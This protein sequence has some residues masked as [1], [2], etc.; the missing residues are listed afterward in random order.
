MRR[1][2]TSRQRGTVYLLVLVVTAMLVGI[3]VT[4]VMAGRI[5]LQGEVLEDDQA[6][7]RH[8][9]KGMLEAIRKKLESSPGWRTK[10][11]HDT[12]SARTNV[13]GG[14]YTYKLV[15]E[16]DGSLSDDDRDPVRVYVKAIVG[17]A[18]RVYSMVL[19]VGVPQRIEVPVVRS[20]DD[21]GQ[22]DLLGLVGTMS[23]A[24]L[25]G[26]DGLSGA[27]AAVRFDDLPVGQGAAVLSAQIQFTSKDS[28][29]DATVMAIAAEDI[30]DAP[31][32]AAVPYSIFSRT[33]TTA[34]VAWIPGRWAANDRGDAQL[35]PDLAEMVQEVVDRPGWEPGNAMVFFVDSTQARYLRTYDYDPD[36]AAVLLVTY[37]DRGLTPDY[38]SL[39]RELVE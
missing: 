6:Q 10:Y 18:V 28:Q 23:N 12:W 13:G 11:A 3:G 14:A 29:S 2:S 4:A 39:R 1:R 37:I 8:L 7:A 26:Q 35:T 30:D 32:F 36:E 34:Q 24:L 16:E 20:S 21:A 27:R 19:Y 33:L 5:D 25:V 31:T 38:T 9:G 22:A 17:N 15:D